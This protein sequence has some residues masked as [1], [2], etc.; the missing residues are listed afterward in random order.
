MAHCA[1]PLKHAKTR[2][3]M[4]TK[5][6]GRRLR[7][8]LQG[9]CMARGYC[10]ML[11]TSEASDLGTRTV[12]APA[13][14]AIREPPAHQAP[15]RRARRSRA[16]SHP[17]NPAL[18]AAAWDC[19]RRRWSSSH[20]R[21]SEATFR[22]P[23]HLQ[24]SSA[25]GRRRRS[26]DQASGSCPSTARPRAAPSTNQSTAVHRRQRQRRRLGRRAPDGLPFPRAVL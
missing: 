2:R 12:H 4:R 9:H 5:A 21:S 26:W 8:D 13:T 18:P 24:R 1:C 22:T 14:A 3:Q 20:A 23:L 10:C 6:P 19:T 11:P 17:P 16:A 25:R 7:K 15:L